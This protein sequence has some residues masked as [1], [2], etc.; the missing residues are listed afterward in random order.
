ML[1][2][3][4]S[5]IERYQHLIIRLTGHYGYYVELMEALQNMRWVVI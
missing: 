1:E 4:G 5:I 3:I 2:P